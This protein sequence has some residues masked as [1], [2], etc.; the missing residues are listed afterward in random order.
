LPTGSWLNP[1]FLPEGLFL[2]NFGW[3]HDCTVNQRWRIFCGW[4]F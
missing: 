4:K 3:A 1:Y 2:V